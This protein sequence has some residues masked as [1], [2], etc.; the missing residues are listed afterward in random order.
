MP[1]NRYTAFLHMNLKSCG[2]ASGSRQAIFKSLAAR[3]KTL[4]ETEK[5]KYDEFA[6]ALNREKEERKQSRKRA[7][8][9]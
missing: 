5:S 7:K 8:L 4:D 3:W 2:T 6:V 1:V 9:D